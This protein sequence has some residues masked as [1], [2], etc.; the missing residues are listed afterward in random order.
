[1]RLWRPQSN[2]PAG[3]AEPHPE[4]VEDPPSPPS[5]PYLLVA[6]H[7]EVQEL[8]EVVLNPGREDLVVVLSSRA[9]EQWPPLDV[10]DVR[11]IVGPGARIYILPTGGLSLDLNE[12]LPG[13]LTPYNGSV[14]TWLPGFG[15]ESD[16]REHP[17]V[18][19]PT[20][21]YGLR[22]L[23]QLAYGLRDALLVR[24]V[25]GQADPWLAYRSLQLVRVKDEA[26]LKIHSLQEQLTQALEERDEAAQRARDE[27][28]EAVKRARKERDEALN[29]EREAARRLRV[30]ERDGGAPEVSTQDPEGALMELILQRWLESLS[31]EERTEHP[32]GPY[33]LGHDFVRSAEGLTNLVRDRLAYV[34]AM[35]VCNRVEDLAALAQSP[36]PQNSHAHHDHASPNGNQSAWQC[37]L[38][39]QDSQTPPALRYLQ[40]A[41][42]TVEFTGMGSYKTPTP[43]RR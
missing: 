9:K 39:R 36:L 12:R 14:G 27:S 33:V 41:D 24:G 16:L 18:F 10:D 26:D 4:R 2:D 7:A 42:G 20:G 29:G 30:A 1:V 5:L 22:A 35:I 32:L 17:I 11:A 25:E 37:S 21:E 3:V 15:P 43:P 34:C 13:R 6:N 28:E 23:R 19:D 40:L 31:L 8:A 38:T